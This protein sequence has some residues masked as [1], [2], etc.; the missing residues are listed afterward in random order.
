MKKHVLFLLISMCMLPFLWSCYQQV[1]GKDADAVKLFEPGLSSS[2]LRFIENNGQWDPRILYKAKLNGGEILFEK[3]K[4]TWHFY[5][6]STHEDHHD[7]PDHHHPS[8]SLFGHVVKT[9]FKGSSAD[10]QISAQSPDQ[11][12]HNYFIGKDPSKWASRVGLFAAIYYEDLYP[13]IDLRI[14]GKGDELKYDLIVEPGANPSKVKMDYLGIDK[15][16]L[17]KGGLAWET[18]IR[19]IYEAAPVSYEMDGN[20]KL[21]EIESQYKLKGNRLSF[22]FPNGYDKKNTLVIDPNL[23]FSTY[24]G[25]TADNWGYTATYD[26]D[27]N[28]YAGGVELALPD[29]PTNG[30]PTTVGAYQRTTNGGQMEVS[31]SKFNPSG[32][33][34]IYATYLG[35]SEDDQPHSLIVNGRNDLIIFGRTNSN[36]FPT[37]NAVSPTL[38]GGFDMFVA[39]LSEDG[40]SLMAS[41]YLGG[42]DDDGVNGAIGNDYSSPT[43]YNYGDDSRGE[44]ILDPAGNIIVAGPTQSENFPFTSGSFTSFLQG[45]QCGIIAKYDPSLT[46]LTWATAF[47]GNGVDAIHTIKTDPDGNVILAGGTSSTNIT[48]TGGQLYSAGGTDGFVAKITAAGN[49]L[50]ACTHLGTSSYDQVYV[51]DIDDEGNIYVAGQSEG[52]IPVV[53]P[54]S[55]VVYENFGAHQFVRKFSSDLNQVIYST[56]IGSTGA[57]SPNIS[58]T[59][60]LVDICQNVYVSGWGGATNQQGNTNGMPTTPDAIQAS[61]D[62]S[63]IYLF[64][65]DRDAQQL[66]YGTYLGGNGE[67]GPFFL[68]GEH[69]DGGTSRFDK[70]GVIY[71]AVCAQCG[72]SANFPTTAGVYA[73]DNGYP[74]NCNLALFKMA[75]D[76]EGIRAEFS[77]ENAGDT[78]FGCAPFQAVFENSSFAGTS[79]GPNVIYDWDFDISGGTSNAFEP[80]FEYL[81]PGT[82]NV[83]LIIIDSTSCNIADTAFRTLTILPNPT[84]DAGEDVLECEGVEIALNGSGGDVYQWSPAAG[85]SDPT[86]PNPSLIVSGNQTFT[87]TVTDVN[88]CSD[89]DEV[90]INSLPA[91]EVGVLGNQTT[92]GGDSVQLQA[93][94]PNAD[95]I[96]YAWSPSTAL[97]DP[98][99]ANPTAAPTVTTTYVVTATDIN[100]CEVRD[101]VRVDILTQP[102]TMITG[103]NRG[104]TGG[105]IE[106]IASGGD[107][108]EWSTGETAPN[109]EV[110]IPSSPT[111][112]IA[113]AFIG[114]CRGIPDTVIV[115]DQFALPEASFSLTPSSGFAPLDISFTNNS[116]D[117][118]NYLWDFGFG[119]AQSREENPVFTYPE[120][121]E[122]TIRLIVDSGFGCTDTAFA[123]LILDQIV[124]NVPNAFTPNGDGTNETFKVVSQGLRNLNLKVFN[125][126]G[127]K[128][129]ET[130][131][132]AF[133]W[134]GTFMGKVVQEG[135]YVW[136]IEGVGENGRKYPRSGTVSILK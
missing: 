32:T 68:T 12:Y 62:G 56:N 105:N 27:G 41:T 94:S 77:L 22:G 135:V 101:S 47:G 96:S 75:F 134:D 60:M 66:K 61:T 10:V 106:L 43:K 93:F 15:I 58:P 52:T 109:I 131:D 9:V 115:D 103:I 90:Q 31:I 97:S 16:E 78:L 104:C 4:I 128:V 121:G 19:D 35:G 91:P 124:L 64:V 20:G 120:A 82:Y 53:N 5:T 76:L 130:S 117:A 14:Y 51:M 125:Q 73:P 99:I 63:D 126:W 24:S 95:I 80:V 37:A 3:D 38:A 122:Y 81:V 110:P 69:V 48:A 79:P 2:S 102:Q 13:G 21:L 129:Y 114:S 83:R 74:N 119:N 127:R 50:I 30:Y 11:A 34:L 1:E 111:Q 72:N 107:R 85:L 8:D 136:T 65:L 29:S 108:Y 112:Y 7:D 39:K 113:V 100:G 123:T 49:S 98:N 92:C 23:V 55:G 84:A 54:P 42:S 36:N 59:A 118:T 28:A 86:L 88:G 87:L 133:E 25:S 116:T 132:P 46:S 57:S 26:A 70:N 45:S 33:N 17:I 71:H 89:T 18:S 40:S 6:Y 67:G 44:V